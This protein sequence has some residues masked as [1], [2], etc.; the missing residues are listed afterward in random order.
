MSKRNKSPAPTGTAFG[1]PFTRAFQTELDNMFGFTEAEGAVRI[2][3][4]TSA[5]QAE[6]LGGWK[7]LTLVLKGKKSGTRK[8]RYLI[9]SIANIER[10][11]GPANIIEFHG[12]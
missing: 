10:I 12:I 9:S 11:P 7:R 2:T 3:V 4:E 6:N 5:P 1:L 8:L